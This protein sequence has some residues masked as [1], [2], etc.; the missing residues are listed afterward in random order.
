MPLRTQ[1]VSIDF[2]LG[3]DEF[4]DRKLVKEGKLIK[5]ENVHF[6]GSKN[7]QKRAGFRT[8]VMHDLE[9]NPIDAPNNVF[10]YK[11]SPI[12]FS[13]NKIY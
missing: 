13:N 12:V 6:D 9:G 8:Q 3:V 11:N 4:T 7:V 1:K 2:G 10:K 5:A